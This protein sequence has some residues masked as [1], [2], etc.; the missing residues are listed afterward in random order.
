MLDGVYRSELDG[1]RTAK[2]ELLTHL[3]AAEGLHAAE[4]IMVGDRAHDMRAAVHHAMKS[5]GVLWG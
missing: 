4:C 1:R 3:L 2:A 5:A